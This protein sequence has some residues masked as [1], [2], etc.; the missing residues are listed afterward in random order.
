[1]FVTACGDAFG[2][3]LIKHSRNIIT[4]GLSFCTTLLLKSN[5]KQCARLSEDIDFILFKN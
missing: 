3:L 2:K 4:V 1:M 5:A